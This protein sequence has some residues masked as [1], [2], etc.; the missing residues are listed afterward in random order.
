ML[1][2]HWCGL[3][4]LV[5]SVLH[6]AAASPDQRFDNI[7][8]SRPLPV[9]DPVPVV[10]RPDGSTRFDPVRALV[11]LALPPPGAPA[12][13]ARTVEPSTKPDP[14]VRNSGR[15]AAVLVRSRSH[16]APA[17][18]SMVVRTVLV[19]TR[20]GWR[21]RRADNADLRMDAASLRCK[22]AVE[23]DFALSTH[24]KWATA[25]AIMNSPDA[26]RV[27]SINGRGKNWRAQP[28]AEAGCTSFSEAGPL[29][30]QPLLSQGEVLEFKREDNDPVRFRI[31]EQL[32][33]HALIE[34]ADGER[35]LVPA[36]PDTVVFDGHLEEAV[37]TWR[38]VFWGDP[39]IASINFLVLRPQP[40]SMDPAQAASQRQR[41][42]PILDYLRSCPPPQLHRVEPCSHPDFATDQ[43]ARRRVLQHIDQ[44]QVP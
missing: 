26:P 13:P 12:P 20:Q 4:V 23:S 3:I 40:P 15:L 25:L 8:P 44:L 7:R 18:M 22:V 21:L 2:R 14:E 31:P 9:Q 29:Y 34:Y 37:V 33:P 35:F 42:Q 27:L 5:G 6:A 32:F 17:G 16:E 39:D 10:T 11:G 38:A 24:H 43:A 41:D 28:G 30:L 19:R 1:S 36:R